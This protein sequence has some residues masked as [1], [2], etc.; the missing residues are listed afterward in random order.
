[1]LKFALKEK[2]LTSHVIC[3]DSWLVDKSRRGAKWTVRE[4]FDYPGIVHFFNWLVNNPG[5]NTK[6]PVYCRKTGQS[7][8]TAKDFLYNANDILIL[9]G[10]PAL[11]IEDLMRKSSLKIYVH[12][13][14]EARKRIFIK[15]YKLRGYSEEDA[16][17]L[18]QNRLEEEIPTIN[19]GQK[20]ADLI[21][22]NI[23]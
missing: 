8:P 2:A 16:L 22:E 20:I 18:Y 3:L 19:K 23:L 4:R 5:K 14:E 9:E 13:E 1:M 6:I 11:D 21:W 17:N 10:V 12:L 15:E 7:N